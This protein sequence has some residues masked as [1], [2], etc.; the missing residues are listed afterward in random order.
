M[1]KDVRIKYKPV[2]NGKVLR[3]VRKFRNE[4]QGGVYEVDLNLETR[5]YSIRNINTRCLVRSTEKDGKTPPKTLDVLKR[6]AR[7]AIQTLGIK[8]EL[9]VRSKNEK[10]YD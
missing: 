1:R 9:E 5:T 6:Q 8:F 2:H 7:R 4:V 10:K 3:S